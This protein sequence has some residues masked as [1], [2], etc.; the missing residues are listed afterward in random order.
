MGVGIVVEVGDPA[1]VE[2]GAAA[3]DAVD[4]VALLQQQL[5]QVGAVLLALEMT[6]NKPGIEHYWFV[7]GLIDK[8]MGIA[9]LFEH[10]K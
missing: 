1:G 3:D 10:W 7:N 4:E 2:G 5:G 6:K 8:S 9:V